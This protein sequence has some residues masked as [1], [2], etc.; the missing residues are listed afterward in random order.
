[1]GTQLILYIDFVFCNFNILIKKE[2]AALAI[3]AQLP[4]AS[5]H[6]LKGHGL[7]RAHISLQVL[8]WSGVYG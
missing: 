8:S 2:T 7:V 6:A 1:M 5:S 3:V 4:G